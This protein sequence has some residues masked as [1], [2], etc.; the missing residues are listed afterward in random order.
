LNIASHNI[1]RPNFA[2]AWEYVAIPDGSSSDAPVLDTDLT[3]TSCYAIQSF[4]NHSVSSFLVHTIPLP[5]SSTNAISDNG[6]PTL[7]VNA[8]S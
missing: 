1:P 7:G 2:P 8:F 4:K 6:F 3:I 5:S